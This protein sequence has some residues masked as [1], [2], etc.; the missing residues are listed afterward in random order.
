MVAAVSQR[1]MS[2][3]ALSVGTGLAFE[4]LYSPIQA[5]IDDER[6]IP[7]KIDLNQYDEFW[8]N[9]MTLFRNMHASIKDSPNSVS[10]RDYALGLKLEIDFIKFLVGQ[11]HPHCKL[12]FY[13]CEYD[14]RRMFPHANLRS[15]K[16]DSQKEYTQLLMRSVSLAMGY[17]KGEEGFH[18]FTRKLEPKA[19]PKALILTNYSF[20]LLSAA[21]FSRLDLLE[22]NTGV[23][24][25]KPKWYT[26]LK[27]AANVETLENMPFCAFTMQIF[28]DSQTFFGW[29]N[30]VKVIVADLAKRHSWTWA[31]TNQRIKLS[32]VSI[33]DNSF[34]YERLN[35]MVVDL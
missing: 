33:K 7:Q 6:E 24:K 3:F 29:P 11:H 2:S 20:D 4:S 34:L 18:I 13:A 28:G 1:E 10:P 19:L 31:T 26:K 25:S 5:R 12:K 23:L 27:K 9:V 17:F 16:K 21:R 8:I 32:L 30:E 35:A 14:I 15:D 22:S